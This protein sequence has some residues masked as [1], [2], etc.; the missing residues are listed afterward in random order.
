[1]TLNLHVPFLTPRGP[2]GEPATADFDLPIGELKSS[3]LPKTNF[4]EV[5]FGALL[6]DFGRVAFDPFTQCASVN[7]EHVGGGGS[8][9]LG[10][11]EHDSKQRGHRRGLK[12]FVQI[13]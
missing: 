11:P 13:R 1:M 8:I 6:F 5:P 7:P 4:G 3:C 10:M 12:P 2:T 9:A